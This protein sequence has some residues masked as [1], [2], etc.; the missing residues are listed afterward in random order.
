[1]T[2]QPNCNPKLGEIEVLDP[3]KPA[4]YSELAALTRDPDNEVRYHAVE[5]IGYSRSRQTT[6]L[7]MNALDDPD[8]LVRVQCLEELSYRDDMGPVE[9]PRIR[10]CLNDRS[11]LVR[12]YAASALA[13]ARD[14]SIIPLLKERLRQVSSAEQC[15]YCFALIELGERSYLETV[16][17]L[18]KTDCY[19]T[20]CS[21]ANCIG[22]FV[23]DSNRKRIVTALLD[24][25]ECETSRAAS[26][27]IA[28][29]LREIASV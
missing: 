18:L 13:T 23:D 1:M 15:S 10:P 21:V 4:D 8:E 5:R 9:A 29:A 24:A 25:L 20:R 26:T 11:E 6:D 12:R 2:S 28:R 16:L 7:L 19:H 3:E 27:T 17:G 14:F 22:A